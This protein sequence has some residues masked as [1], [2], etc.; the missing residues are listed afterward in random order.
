M[1]V[2][3]SPLKEDFKW[4]IE[5]APFELKIRAKKIPDWQAVNGLAHLPVS[6]REGIYKGN[7][8][9]KIE[10]INLIP[11]GFTKLRIQA[12]PVVN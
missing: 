11:V 12:F 3:S 10:T 2:S 7:V 4:N 1:K 6:G 8:T 9:D 5:N